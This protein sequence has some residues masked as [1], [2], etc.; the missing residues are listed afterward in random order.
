[1]F[2]PAYQISYIHLIFYKEN[3][4]FTDNHNILCIISIH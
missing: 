3:L 2:D 1:M 4:G